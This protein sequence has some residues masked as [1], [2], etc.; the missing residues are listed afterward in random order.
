MIK[1][2]DINTAY[3]HLSR[4]A[5]IKLGERVRQGQTIGYVGMTGLATG[6][7]L[8]YEFRVNGGHRNPLTVTLPPAEPL[9]KT[10]LA[11]FRQASA[12]M[13]ARLKNLDRIQLARADH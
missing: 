5:G 6:P 8:H 9:P 2:Q 12:P 13:L 3:G 4:F 1:I 7:H 10:E 11:Q